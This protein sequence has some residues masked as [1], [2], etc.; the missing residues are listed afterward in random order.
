MV[1][2]I[3][4]DLHNMT[5]PM[6]VSSQIYQITLCLTVLFS[7]IIKVLFFFSHSQHLSNFFFMNRYIVNSLIRKNI[8]KYS[9]IVSSLN[10][11]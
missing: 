7:I 2:N 3:F 1:E 5:T 11:V 8:L 6:F 4:H 10:C 9:L